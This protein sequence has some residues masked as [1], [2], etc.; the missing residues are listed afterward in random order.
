MKKTLKV[1]LSIIMTL[2]LLVVGSPITAVAAGTPVCYIDGN[3]TPFYS[4]DDAISAAEDGDT[5]NV[6][7]DGEFEKVVINKDLTLTSTNGSTLAC[8][9]NAANQMDIQG[10]VTISGNLKITRKVHQLH[11]SW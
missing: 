3:D 2:A 11:C 10:D 9:S 8:N 4:L 1:T 7:A 5:I 6:V